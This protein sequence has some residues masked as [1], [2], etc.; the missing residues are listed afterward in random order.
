MSIRMFT[1]AMALLCSSL[2]TQACEREIR[3]D[4]GKVGR[5]EVTYV[6]C[7]E[8]SNFRPDLFSHP[9]HPRAELSMSWYSRRAPLS[10]GARVE[11]DLDSLAA[12]A[13]I[14]EKYKARVAALHEAH[15]P[16]RA[17]KREKKAAERQKNRRQK[18]IERSVKN[19]AKSAEQAQE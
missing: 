19:Q 14:N 12:L 16:N 15:P 5:F 17:W 8:D 1:V 18:L 13:T 7:Q 9:D 11:L 6:E 2:V 3:E 4:W 10:Q